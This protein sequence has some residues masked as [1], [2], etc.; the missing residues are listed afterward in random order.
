[1]NKETVRTRDGEVLKFDMQLFAEEE[2]STA[3]GEKNSAGENSQGTGD[4]KEQ[5]QEESKPLTQSDIDRAVTKALETA[6]KK[7]E[8][9]KQKAVD[10]AI[11][12]AKRLEKLSADERE[13]ELLNKQKKE[14]EDKE[15]AL[16]LKD[17]ELK[18]INILK[19]N[20]L[21]MEF[22]PFIMGD[23][24]ESTVERTKL[25]KEVWNKALEATKTE[26]LKGKPPA[27]NDNQ[28][29]L[30]MPTNEELDKMTMAEYEAW[31]SKQK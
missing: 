3:E 27:G 30:G 15:K 9:D 28:Q 1:M 24:E 2:K 26:L 6:R 14:L 4:Q 21:P 10:D 18:T 31:R 8:E 20:E 16:A 22:K 29:G 19:E 25:F 17:L 7:S 13:K 12:E 5:K 23:S 11:A